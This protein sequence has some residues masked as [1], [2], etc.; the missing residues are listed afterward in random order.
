MAEI[1]DSELALASLANDVL[2]LIELDIFF[3]P[4]NGVSHFSDN[5]EIL[6]EY[7]I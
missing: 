3:K 5:K 4:E 2:F 1:S 7:A 6:S